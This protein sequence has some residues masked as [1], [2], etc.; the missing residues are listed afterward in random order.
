MEKRY[1]MKMK[2][3]KYMYLQNNFNNNNIR[4]PSD[5]EKCQ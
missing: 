5:Y 3:N 1:F 4:V 2:M